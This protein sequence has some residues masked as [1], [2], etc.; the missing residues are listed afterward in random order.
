[1]KIVNIDESQ[2]LVAV[3]WC[4]PPFASLYSTGCARAN[5]FGARIHALDPDDEFAIHWLSVFNTQGRLAGNLVG[6]WKPRCKHPD[7]RRRVHAWSSAICN[8]TQHD[9]LQDKIKRES[10]LLYN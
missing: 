7:G 5:T 6:S 8:S 3:D 9:L 4:A 1:M 2:M 10:I